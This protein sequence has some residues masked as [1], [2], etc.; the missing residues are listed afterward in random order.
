MQK[1]MEAENQII[2]KEANLD[3]L[4]FVLDL[5]NY[6]L[7]NTTCTFDHEKISLEELQARLSHDNKKYKTFLVCD[8]TA[9]NRI[10]FC[11]LTQFRKKPAY[12]CHNIVM[13]FVTNAL[14]VKGSHLFADLPSAQA[15]RV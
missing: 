6:Y 11:F 8:E 14:N 15:G 2:F 5:Y 7:S 9:K 13:T 4:N 10:G 3:D 1:N 12:D